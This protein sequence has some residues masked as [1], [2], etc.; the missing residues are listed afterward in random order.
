MGSRPNEP[1]FPGQG[2]SETLVQ[3][4]S[5]RNLLA[6]NLYNLTAALLGLALLCCAALDWAAYS[7]F[8]FSLLWW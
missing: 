2:V 7:G 4:M 6:T 1:G 8:M 5:W 3:A